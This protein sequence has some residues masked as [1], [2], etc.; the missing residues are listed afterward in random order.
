MIN[1]TKGK[2][3]AKGEDDMLAKAKGKKKAVVPRG[4]EEEREVGEDGPV[5]SPV[6]AYTP[7]AIRRKAID[8]AWW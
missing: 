2:T 6:T 5:S 1:K 4:L 3:E 7:E 8:D